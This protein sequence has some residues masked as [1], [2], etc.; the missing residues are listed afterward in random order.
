SR[1]AHIAIACGNN[2][3]RLAWNGNLKV[4]RYPVL[5]SAFIIGIEREI[6]AL[7]CYLGLGPR[8]PF[9]GITLVLGINALVYLDMN[10]VIPRI[11]HI[12]RAAQI[13][14]AQCGSGGESLLKLVVIAVIVAKKREVFVVDVNFVAN[15]FP[16]ESCRLRGC[17]A[18]R[19][20][21]D[22]Q[23]HASSADSPC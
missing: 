11:N 6:A 9:V 4:Y 10:L 20:E 22:Y 19:D 8:I 17:E 3:R 7:T 23:E 16:V 12:H 2:D 14:N 21:H 1:D 13:V 5:A 18:E 15:V